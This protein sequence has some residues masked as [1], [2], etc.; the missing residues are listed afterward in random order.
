MTWLLIILAFLL[1]LVGV[2]GAI[3]PGIAG[4]PFSFL[5]LLAMS[6]VRGID[7]SVE[8]LVVMGII[9][10]VVFVLDYVVPIWGTKKLGGTKAGVRGSTIGL[11]LGLLITILFPIGF[12]AILLGPFF[13]A[14]IGEKTNGTDDHLAWRSAFGSF[15]GFLT[16]TFLKL[17]YAVVCI[18]Y[19]VKD[20]IG[21]I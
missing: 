21:L 6:F 13:G 4:P 17:V 18:Y 12:I 11:I 14:Y 3:V 5:G 10:A 15:V 20:L 16:G 9:G 19:I 2:V 8:F 1:S 7:Y